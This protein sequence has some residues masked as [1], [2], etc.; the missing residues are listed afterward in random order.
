MLHLLELKKRSKRHGWAGALAVS[1]QALHNGKLLTSSEPA[2]PSPCWGRLTS[3]PRALLGAA[4]CPEAPSGGTEH[5]CPRLC[6]WAPG[7]LQ[8]RACLTAISSHLLLQGFLS[9]PLTDNSVLVLIQT[10][11]AALKSASVLVFTV[12]CPVSFHFQDHIK[13]YWTLVSG[14]CFLP[15]CCSLKAF[16]SPDLYCS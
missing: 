1:P 15:H 2:V 14:T 11:W 8:L 9:L 3:E 13:L 5:R 12:T 16:I 6:R 10:C 7:L 4:G